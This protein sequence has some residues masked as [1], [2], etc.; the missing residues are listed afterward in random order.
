[1][2]KLAILSAVLIIFAGCASTEEGELTGVQDR[3]PWYVSDPFGMVLVPKGS[4]R[5]GPNDQDVP[6]ATTA[7]SKTVSIASFY[8]DQTEITNN[9]YRQFVHWVR[10]SL[11]YRMLGEQI[12]EYLI[13]EDAFGEAIE[14]PFINWEMEI[15]WDDQEQNEILQDLFYP[16]HERFY[17]RKSIDP[18]KL[19]YEYFWIDYKQAA[20]KFT[21]D[22]ENRR[23][24]NYKTGQYDGEIVGLD[25][26]KIPIKDRS[27]FIMRDMVNVY[28]DTLCWISDFSYSYNEP[29]ANMYFWHASYDNYPVVGVSWKQAT[30]FSIWR[31][32]YQNGF[33]AGAGGHFV[34]DYR[35]PMESEWEYAA[36]GGMELAVYPWG[37]PYTRN[38]MG[39]FL[40]NFKPM[41]GDYV[42]D[43]G[44]HTTE[45][46]IYE[47]NDYGLYDMAGNVSEWTANAFDESSYS[48]THDLNP[49]YQFNALPDDPPALKRKVVRGG[50]W[51]DIGYYMQN[52][53]RTYEYQD[54]AKA[55]IGFR[56]VR[57]YMGPDET[58]AQSNVY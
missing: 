39:C 35:L 18:R 4:Y 32:A 12:D 31:T 55:Y 45:V 30:A 40:A 9:E 20:Q 43:G 14:P 21:F 44:L 29:M 56:C 47:A 41:R 6:W 28:P 34:Q 54:T 33:L 23:H 15:I 10:D 38:D 27:S 52:G 16:E 24:Y 36:R 17:R 8:M 58:G 1:M 37:G 25:G 22:N 51:K 26:K 19:N 3:A 13:S 2:K 50:S 7:Q 57:S 5:Q 11:A 53:T 42:L 48:F 49:Y 46:A